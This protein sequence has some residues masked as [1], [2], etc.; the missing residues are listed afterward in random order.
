MTE[1]SGDLGHLNRMGLKFL[2]EHQN[3]KFDKEYHSPEV[4][5][6]KIDVIRAR[7]PDGPA[8][9]LDVGGGNGR[10]LDSLLSAFP[11]ANGYIIDPSQ[12]LLTRNSFNSR[13]HLV[14][15][16]VDQLE[17][18]FP[19]QT[20]DIITTNWVLHHLVGSTWGQ[21]VSNAANAL[22]IAGRLLSPNGM[23]IVA[24]DMY[25]GIL[26]GDLPSRVI[27]A[28]TSIKNRW[29]AKLAGR[30]ANTAGVGVCFHSQSAWEALFKRIGFKTEQKFFGNY[31]PADLKTRLM[32]LL[33][34]ITSRR[35]GHYFLLPE[36][37]SRT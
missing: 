25:N 28:V 31:W 19:N 13:K 21:C 33:I 12:V 24:E 5:K 9:I 35:H 14:Q 27:Y 1:A 8:T 6:R 34:T 29:F 11:T 4:M 32:L 17:E 16:S 22:E 26:G 37:F 30:Y 20:F 15:G 3:E 36:G 18:I 10:F 7:F 23:I 2:A